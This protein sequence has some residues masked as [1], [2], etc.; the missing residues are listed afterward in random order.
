M[1]ILVRVDFVLDKNPMDNIITARVACITNCTTNALSESNFRLQRRIASLKF[2][3]RWSNE[4]GVNE[5]KPIDPSRP[6]SVL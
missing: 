2:V 5:T 1:G 4:H 3:T 6:L